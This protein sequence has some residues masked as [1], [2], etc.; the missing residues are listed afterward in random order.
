MEDLFVT[1][2][3][4]KKLLTLKFNET[5]CRVYNVEVKKLGGIGDPII[6]DELIELS[7]KKFIRAPFY[8]QVINWLHE[9]HNIFVGVHYDSV[10][11]RGT[12]CFLIHKDG[13]LKHNESISSHGYKTPKEAW[14]MAIKAA[15]K[16]VRK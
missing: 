9:K 15:L 2:D 13:N 5:C 10:I 14:S 3:I 7:S 1:Y 16:L 12:F 11:K 4:A 8:Q 6:V